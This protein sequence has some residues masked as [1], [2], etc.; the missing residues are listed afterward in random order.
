L[1]GKEGEIIV[2][3]AE[4]IEQLKMLPQDNDV[5]IDDWEYGSSPITELHI[6]YQKV[7]LLHN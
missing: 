4:L 3:I 6:L 7:V 5:E 2:T 1:P